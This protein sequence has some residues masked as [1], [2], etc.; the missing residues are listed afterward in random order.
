MGDQLC[1]PPLMKRHLQG[2]EHQIGPQVRCHGPSDYAPAPSIQ[3]DG[4]EEES[5]CGG[6]V[7]DIGDPELVRP[8]GGEARLHQVW[9]RSCFLVARG[10]APLPPPARTSQTTYAHQTSH[11]LVVDRVPLVAQ[12]GM[13]TRT[14][15]GL[16]TEPMDPLDLGEQFLISSRA[17]RGQPFPPGVVVTGGRPSTRHIARTGKQAWFCFTNSNPARGS[18]CSPGRAV[19]CTRSVQRHQAAAFF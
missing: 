15:V 4:Q 11:A 7:G 19:R 18:S 2:L 12:L 6:N 5:R 1:R 14:S 10:G 3:H 13:H 9:R 16:T 8:R 17:R